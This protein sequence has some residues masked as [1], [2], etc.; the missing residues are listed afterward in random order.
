MSNQVDLRRE[1]I[2]LAERI[3][4][5]R[6]G[7]E[8]FDS[9]FQYLILDDAFNH[10]IASLCLQHFPTLSDDCWE[11]SNI[12][13]VEVKARS[14]WTSEFDS[15][16]GVVDVI[17]ILNSAPILR[18]MSERFQIPK[19][20]PDPYFTGGGLN[21]SS[22]GGHLDI[23]VDG[24]YHDAS[25]MHRRMNALLYLNPNYQSDWGGEFGIY[26]NDGEALVKT[27]EPVHNRLLIFD[28]HDKSYHGIPNPVKCPPNEPRKSIILYFYTVEP[29]PR[30][31]TTIEEPH[32]ALW[33]SKGF[34]DKLGN[35]KRDFT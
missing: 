3:V 18:A 19:L 25:G 23:H 2:S 24:N 26:E 30:H 1:A 7:A 31:V 16:D 29:R 34:T 12:P 4:S 27:V 14:T 17:R 22:S 6:S 5:S 15:P 35:T 20:M 8:F 11:F 10:K 13:G 21:C 9:P 28:S 32:S 33:K